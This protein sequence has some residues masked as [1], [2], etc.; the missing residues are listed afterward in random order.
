MATRSEACRPRTQVAPSQRINVERG[1]SLVGHGEAVGEDVPGEGRVR[2][3]RRRDVDPE[4]SSVCLTSLPGAAYLK[5]AQQDRVKC[6]TPTTLNSWVESRGRS[7]KPSVDIFPHNRVWPGPTSGSSGAHSR[8][9]RVP[10]R[11][12]RVH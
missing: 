3:R 9:A 2:A 5:A 8:A 7:H 4:W 10:G 11:S 1:T 6:S 12:G